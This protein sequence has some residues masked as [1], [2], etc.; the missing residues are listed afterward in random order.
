VVSHYYYK[1]RSDGSGFWDQ[2][3]LSG[4][5]IQCARDREWLLERDYVYANAFTYADS[6]ASAYPNTYAFADTGAN[7]GTNPRSFTYSRQMVEVGS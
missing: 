7:G 3:L 2:V 5:S 4:D 6:N 1:L